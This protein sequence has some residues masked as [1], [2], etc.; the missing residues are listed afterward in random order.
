MKKV[1]VSAFKSFNN[2]TTNYSLE[3]LKYISNVEKI[4][5]D[6]LYDECYRNIVKEYDLAQFDLIIS[7]GEARSRKELTLETQAINIASCSIP[8]NNGVYKKNQV[9]IQD[10]KDVIVT[11]VNLDNIKDIVLLSDNAGKYVCNNL[12]YHLL[13]NY[14]SKSLFIHIPNC[15]DDIEEYKKYAKVIENII[16]RL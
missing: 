1:L 13:Y 15:N 16:E 12:Y 10:G 3:V 11:N 5:V 14:P 4:I 9:I 8:D 2:A 6:V 7:L